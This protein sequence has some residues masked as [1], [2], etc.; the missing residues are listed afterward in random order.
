MGR[1]NGDK[2]AQLYAFC[3]YL[4]DL[5]DDG[6]AHGYTRI[7]TMQKKLSGADLP[8]GQM[9]EFAR[10]LDFANTNHLSVN[11][12]KCLMQWNLRHVN[13]DSL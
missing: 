12:C 13:A 9:D 5:A 7:E 1:E 4:D 3:R 2:A 11:S 10:F 6:L 8:P